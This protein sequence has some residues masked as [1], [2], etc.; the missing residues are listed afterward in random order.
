MTRQWAAAALAFAGPAHGRVQ[1]GP[2]ACPPLP[3][4]LA[5]ARWLALRCLRRHRHY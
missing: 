2:Y 5:A 3:G 4:D 1:A